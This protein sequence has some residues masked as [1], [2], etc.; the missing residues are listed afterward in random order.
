MQNA[1]VVSFYD[2]NMVFLNDLPDV[3]TSPISFQEST[4]GGQKDI[5]IECSYKFEERPDF[6]NEGNY[7][8]ITQLNNDYAPKGRLVYSGYIEGLDPYIKGGNQGLTITIMG[9]VGLLQR[10]FFK[11][12]GALSRSYVTTDPSIVIAD[13]LSSYQVDYPS[14][15]NDFIGSDALSVEGLLIR[16][17]N[18]ISSTGKSIGFDFD[19]INHFDAIKKCLELTGEDW[20]WKVDAGGDFIFKAK[21]VSATHSFTVGKDIQDI[22]PRRSISEVV[23]KVYAEYDS[24]LTSD[25][26]SVS[27]NDFG[28]SEDIINE[29]TA[30]LDAADELV[31]QKLS[32][33]KDKKSFAKITINNQYDTFSIKPGDTCEVLNIVKNNDM[34][35]DNMFIKSVTYEENLCHLTL[36]DEP[37]EITKVLK[38]ATR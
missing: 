30:D 12:A 17:G 19:K 18:Q 10:S 38:N 21:P 37:L 6:I 13:V 3:K 24:G 5:T 23:N 15:G 16:V 32:S 1:F 11:D 9:L 27:V 29:S 28:L 22:S 8:R 20:F 7:V 31:A 35:N 26:D 33:S 2:K 36:E 14:S 4:N 34:F 25:S